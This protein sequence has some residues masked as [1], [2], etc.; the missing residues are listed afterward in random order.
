MKKT[1]YA[2]AIIITTPLFGS[3][4]EAII[5]SCQNPTNSNQIFECS[6]KE[7]SSADRKLNESYKKLL[8]RVEKQYTTSPE[9]KK[10]L[11]QEIRKSQRTWITLRDIDCNL[12]AFQIETRSQA[13]ETTVN[14]CIARLSE[15][16]SAY[17]DNNIS[18]DF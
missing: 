10:Q 7:R 2:T 11:T 3:A 16:R 18:P 13:Y 14:K 1:L 5:D 15:A 8:T 4:Q 17:L 6:E 12:E 9:L